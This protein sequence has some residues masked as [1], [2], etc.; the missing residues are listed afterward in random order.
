MPKKICNTTGC[1]KL[2]DMNRTHCI[3]HGTKHTQY[4]KNNRDTVRDKFYHSKAWKCKRHEIMQMYGG[5]CQDC[6]KE[7]VINNADVIDHIIEIKDG[8][9]L[10][11][12]DNLIPLCHNHHNIKT[13][14]EKKQRGMGG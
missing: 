7:D 3:D 12:N 1:S 4:D 9:E 5:L 2:I 10:L 6:L 8:G 11:S 14:L 13:K